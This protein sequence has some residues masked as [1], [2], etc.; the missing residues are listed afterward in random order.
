MKTRISHLLITVA[1]VV[2]LL[3][4][5]GLE[6]ELGKF[7]PGSLVENNVVQSSLPELRIKVAP[8]LGYIGSVQSGSEKTDSYAST[9]ISADDGTFRA[10]SYLFGETGPDTRLKRGVIVRLL[11]VTGNPNQ[12]AQ[13]RFLRDIRPSGTIESGRM[14]IFDEEYAS[15]LFFKDDIFTEAEK[16]L[17]KGKAIPSCTLVRQ[18]EKK[19]GFG[20]KSR[21]IISYFEELSPCSGDVANL[22][23]KERFLND[24]T[25]RSYSAV[26]FLEPEKTF[27][28][29][30]RYTDPDRS[31]S[32]SG[33]GR[34]G[35]RPDMSGSVEKR[36]QALKDLYDKNLISEEDY[37]KKKAEIL[38]EL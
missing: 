1:A 36:L 9:S 10:V 16:G 4:C 34:E 24:F 25:E 30:P 5:S 28:A 38:G 6:K 19:E 15:S 22:P 18:I 20:N 35:V 17:L 33:K 31:G 21:A 29:T 26:R 3:G 13:Q 8:D 7:G 37:E 2:L 23:G 12:P 14:K 32:S 11:A 27:D